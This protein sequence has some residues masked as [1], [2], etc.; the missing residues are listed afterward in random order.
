MRL[1]DRAANGETQADPFG[2]RREERLKNAFLQGGIELPARIGHGDLDVPGIV[3][4]RA[5]AQTRGRALVVLIASMPFMIRLS[6]TWR[7]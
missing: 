5:N 2:L 3:P 1:D 7:N 6:I 4:P